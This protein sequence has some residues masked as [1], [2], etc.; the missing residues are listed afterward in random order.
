MI[1]R[2]IRTAAVVA[3]LSVG[4][5]AQTG[6]GRPSGGDQ[7]N[8]VVFRIPE[9]VFPMDW[10]K[11]GF[12]GLLFLQ[13]DSPSGIFVGYPND[14]E[15]VA[16]FKERAIKFISPM[17]VHDKD[18]AASIVLKET[19]IPSHEGDA[20]PK[21]QMF[22]YNKDKSK[23]QILVYE[24]ATPSGKTCVYGYFASVGAK[25]NSEKI[26]ADENGQGVK[27]FEKFWKSFKN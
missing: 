4:L 25:E 21:G 10:N 27:I 16:S 2:I 6:P 3:V 13:K 23:L 1:I 7:A 9:G 15:S 26:W 20:T 14:D 11:S 5:L 22:S 12:K 8:G 17:F 19:D 24:R 18:E